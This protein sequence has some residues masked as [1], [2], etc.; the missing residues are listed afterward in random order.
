MVTAQIE[1]NAQK[2]W[3]EPVSTQRI[4]VWYIEL[5]FR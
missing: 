2:G 4:H 1:D 3:K 5:H